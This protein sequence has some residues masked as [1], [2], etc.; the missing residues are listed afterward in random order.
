M[1]QARKRPRLRGMISPRRQLEPPV[2]G[3]EA[4]VN[5]DELAASAA[6]T[7]FSRRSRRARLRSCRASAAGSDRSMAAAS[8]AASCAP[9]RTAR[10]QAIRAAR[11]GE[12]R[13]R[14]RC[15]AA[16]RA[17]D[18]P[19]Q[20]HDRR[21]TQ[22]SGRRRQETE[23][24]A[25]AANA[26]SPDGGDEARPWGRKRARSP[27][28]TGAARA[29][30]PRFEGQRDRRDDSAPAIGR[31]IPTGATNAAATTRR[32]PRSLSRRNPSSGRQIQIRLSQTAGA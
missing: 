12:K 20:R 29:I 21:R 2:F 6:R 26:P 8:A 27:A 10:R 9:D 17:A 1:R 15:R 22:P 7:P 28:W 16:A 4:G 11:K 23:V 13:R 5:A 30:G 24:H 31:T 32:P 25:E 18:R 19:A 3:L 14:A